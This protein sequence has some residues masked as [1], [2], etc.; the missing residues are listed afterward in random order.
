[1]SWRFHDV[2]CPADDCC[3]RGGK[4]QLMDVA[5]MDPLPMFRHGLVAALG[6]GTPLTSAED[7]DAWVGGTGGGLL[8]LT[9]ADDTAWG[10]LRHL[11]AASHVHVVAV[12]TGFDITT[13]AG[14][15]RAGAV[16]A[17]GRDADADAFRAVVGDVA[18]GV[19]TLP[20]AVMRA[21]AA[22]PDAAMVGL[23]PSDEEIR[24]LREL[25]N[26]STVAVLARKLQYSERALY[27][28]LKDLYR[29]LGVLNRT[30][31]LI[32][33]REQGWL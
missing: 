5:V 6:R 28:R 33:A 21:V 32:L 24:W 22:L 26:G 18:R 16:H 8:M 9:M 15:L 14:A 27:R 17:L 7:L 19:V 23:P 29:K 31:A 10:V 4:S 13:A 3:H 30:Q 12:L 11:R 20:A 1:M 2:L 25:A